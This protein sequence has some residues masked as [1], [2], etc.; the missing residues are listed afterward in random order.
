MVAH[1]LNTAI[2]A[3]GNTQALVVGKSAGEVRD[4]V[5]SSSPDIQVFEQ[6]ER[7]G[8]AH[9]VLAAREAFSKEYDD[10][11][12]LFGDTPLT[13]PQTLQTMR[14]QLEQGA[15]VV[16]L[17]FETK[18]P[19][20]Y[21]RLIVENGELTA[22][23]EE[24]DASEAEKAITFCNGG[25]VAIAGA[26]AEQLLD[27]IGNENAKGEYYLTDIVEI[28]R[29]EGGRAVALRADEDEVLGI[30]TRAE[31]AR[32]ETIWQARMREKMMLAGVAMQ[33]PETVFLQHD[34]ELGVDCVVE[35]NV[36]F[37]PDVKIETGATIRS[38][39]HLEGCRIG[40]NATVGPFA[41][42]RPGTQ[43]AQGSR[44]G[45]FCEL[46][47]VEVGEGAK[48]N[49]LSYI[50]DASVGAS[51]NIGAGTITCNY[52]GVAKH[53]TDI[54]ANAFI[55]SNSALVAPVTIGDN[56]YVASGSVIVEDVPSEALAIARGRQ[57]IKTGRAKKI[58]E[59]AKAT[60]KA[61]TGK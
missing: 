58:M 12:I 55:G 36:V 33:A 59:R 38:F 25:I 14:D 52:D 1:V 47:N 27:S 49:H 5:H 42:I 34:T 35:P 45:N 7:L 39:S 43:M 60:K 8:T 10:I 44:V 17:G 61:T 6:Q 13:Q 11:L 2:A 40:P 54:G 56:A 26:R 15:E 9:A 3:G 32:V 53:R 51:A 4:A 37:G 19:T 46:K 29:A 28:S 23:R 41:R 21:G 31:M 24:R 18:N 22:I 30:N 48:I 57:S 20:G 50:G 16:V